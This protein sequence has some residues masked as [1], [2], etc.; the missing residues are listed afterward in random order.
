MA[1]FRTRSAAV[2]GIDAHLI[3]VEVDM[4]SSGSAR[5]SVMVGMPDTAVRE[6]RERIKS[7]LMNS[8]FGYP[9]KQ[10]TINLAPANVR[11]EGAGFDLPVALGILGAMGTIAPLDRHIA[12]GELSLDGAIRPVRGALSVAVCARQLGIDTLIL[13][14]ENAAEAAVVDGVR[15]YGV[16]Y[17]A[18]V[19]A[20]L[21]R[22]EEFTPATPS[23][24]GKPA[25]ASAVP[26]FRDVR[27]QTM[28]KRA[29]EVA[30]AGGH[31]VLLIGPPGS[32]KTMLAK[33]L[34][35][36]LP[37]LTFDEAI[38]TTRVHSVAGVLARGQGLLHERPFRSPHHTISDAGMIGGGAGV[39]RP[40]EVSLAHNGVLFLD[41]FPEFPRD[42][43]EILRQPLE[44]GSV[45]IARSSMT[46]RF[47]S[48]FM[49][50]AAMNPC[51]CGFFGDS[52]RECRCTPAMVQ[53]YLGKI[54][55]PL[56][57]RID[58]HVEVPAVP[59]KEL[60]GG[61]GAE[62]SADI[63][64]RVDRARAVQH[65]RGH[66]NSRMPAPLIRK[67]C[68]LDDSGERTLEL[69]V[70][71]MGL[72]ARAHDRVLKVARTV[73]DLAESPTVSAKHVA[74]AVQYRSLDRNYWN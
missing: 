12:M 32:G 63:R 22:P 13:P 73:A 25:D 44:D 14:A 6:S 46:L 40:G 19:V 67:Q 59:F 33:R 42:V 23:A 2:Y 72:S 64:V 8:G 9:N 24:N 74:E 41:E 10:I 62:S 43:L 48:H 27:G 53:R 60:R 50:V 36:I 11:K 26:D 54:S 52:T 47:P 21:A 38:E 57:D 15:V 20:L 49:L 69:A 7:A 18:E 45:T 30:A 1:L 28:A 3:D 39:P 61:E 66:Y 31:N 51:A 37:P 34:A 71:R 65:T 4:F 16:R 70:R 55:G 5:D 58:I 56:L 17:L 29:L 35:G 68:A